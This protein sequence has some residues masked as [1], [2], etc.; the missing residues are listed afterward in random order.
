[1]K[2]SFLK[3]ALLVLLSV[4][5]AVSALIPAVAAE[6]LPAADGAEIVDDV[7]SAEE[8]S[9]ETSEAAENSGFQ[10]MNFV[11]NLQYMGSG[12]LCIIIVM[13]VLI[14]A[15]ILLNKITKPKDEKKD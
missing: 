13:G 9:E 2:A 10:P 6:E 15:T 3:K 12:M 7:L 11:R 5:F 4:I 14:G 8:G 1:M